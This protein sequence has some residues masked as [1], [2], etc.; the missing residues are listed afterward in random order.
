[1]L[2]EAARDF[3]R[4]AEYFLLAAEQAAHIS[5]NKE[6][7]VLA[8]HG[9]EALK[10]V[11]ETPQRSQLE[12]RLQTIL[13]P[14]L[15]GTVGYAA[16]EVEAVY[17]RARELCHQVGETPRLFAVIWGHYQYWL[18]RAEYRT[19]R[20]LA[21]QLL[22]SAQKLQDPA[23]LLVAHGALANICWLC[24]DFEAVRAHAEQAIPIYVPQQHHRLASLYG[25]RDP[26]VAQRSGAAVSLWLLGYPDQALQRCHEG[27]TLAREL[28]HTSSIVFALI[29]DGIVHQHCGDAR[30]T[31]QQAEAAIALAGEQQLP[32]WLAWGTALRGWAL[33]EQ[34]ESEEG[35]AQLRQGIAGW[36][37]V[38]GGA[39]T[40]YFLALLADAYGKTGK[41]EEGLATLAEA[42]TITEQ[43]H[44]GYMESELYRLKGELQ[45]EV[46]DAEACF[47]QAIGIAQRQK[48]KSFELRAVM[49]LSRLYQKHGRQAEARQ[50]LGEIYGRFTEGFDTFDLKTAAALLA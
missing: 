12:L 42:L 1:M 50:M 49:S 31:R 45:R 27:L 7:V 32:Q 26:G 24:G 21:E 18:A 36:R 22:T 23:L 6:A 30:Q 9:L 35:I 29:F 44:E 11:A 46:T 47:H 33:V 39:L 10:L 20:E 4:A 43:T 2:F 38:R 37:A 8:R 17:T 41:L 19:A 14:A 5:A 34:G 15:M 28:A 13:G 40:P 3:E 25:G 48:A 16:R